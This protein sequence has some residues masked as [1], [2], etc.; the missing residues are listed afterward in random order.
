MKTSSV[1]YTAIKSGRSTGHD[2][3]LCNSGAILLDGQPIATFADNPHGAAMDVFSID[4]DDASVKHFIDWLNNVATVTMTM[5]G[6]TSEAEYARL[7]LWVANQ[8]NN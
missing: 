6:I 8:L 3:V 7:D 5:H 1:D 2:N 4:G